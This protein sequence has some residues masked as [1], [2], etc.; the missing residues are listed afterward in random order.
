MAD[1]T[2]AEVATDDAPVA[3]EEPT[4]EEDAAA[5]D[6]EAGDAASD[7]EQVAEP[8]KTKKPAAKRG[9]KKTAAAKKGA[10]ESND[11]EVGIG[12]TRA[13]RTVRAPAR[14][15]E[16]DEPLHAKH[17]LVIKPGPGLKLGSI[18]SIK[19]AVDKKKGSDGVLK[20]L[21]RIL[22]NTPG[23]ARMVKAHIRDFSGFVFEDEKE[24]AK[25]LE[26]LERHT[27]QEIKEILGILCLSVRN[28]RYRARALQTL[29]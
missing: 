19:E 3:I 12:A 7:T 6:T 14:L 5:G 29:F 13:R 25:I 26:K 4:G 17:T 24:E 16:P 1:D 15:A 21:H 22:Y 10:D 2:A 27:A 11:E 23:E 9:A 18:S 8:A 28:C 20:H